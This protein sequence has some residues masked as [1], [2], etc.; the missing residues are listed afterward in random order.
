[1]PECYI[2]CNKFDIKL[3]SNI[4]KC[5]KRYIHETCLQ[6]L[7]E[8]QSGLKCK[9]PDYLLIFNIFNKVSKSDFIFIKHNDN[10]V[11]NLQI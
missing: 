11:F 4:C 3:L 5:K 6:T 10:G 2:C 9:L 8:M 1:M 7:L